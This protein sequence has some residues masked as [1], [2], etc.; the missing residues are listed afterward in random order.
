MSEDKKMNIEDLSITE[1]DFQESEE[2]IREFDYLYNIFQLTSLL[3]ENNH[4]T[5][6]HEFEELAKKVNLDIEMAQMIDYDLHPEFELTIR[7]VDHPEML[8]VLWKNAFEK[9]K[10]GDTIN[11]GLVVG[12]FTLTIWIMVNESTDHEYCCESECCH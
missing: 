8:R 9:A 4:D 2:A 10:V 3:K 7:S 12:V 11:G 1:K 5:K 6:D